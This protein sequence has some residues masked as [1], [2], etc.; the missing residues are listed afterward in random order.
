MKKL[1]LL[2]SFLICFVGFG[3]SIIVND[4]AAPETNFTP[5]ELITE[6]LIGGEGCGDVNFQLLQE[7]PEGTA[8]IA[9]RSWGYFDA[10]GTNFPFASG[11]ILSTGLS[12]DAQGP[13]TETGTTGTGIGWGGDPDLK[14][15]LDLQSGDNEPTN[16]ATIFQFSFVPVISEISFD[17]IFASEEYEN[18]FECDS[19]YRDGFAFLLRGPGIPNDSGTVFGGTNIAAVPG[20]DGIPV[21]TL[22]I[23]DGSFTCGTE[24]EGTNFFPELYISNSGTNNA[25]EIE[26]DG[27]TQ[28]LTAQANLTPGETYELKMVIAD[29][30]DTSFDSAVFFNAGSF[31]IGVNLGDDFT[32]N[33]GNAPCEGE[34]FEI[35]VLPSLNT[36]Y[37]WYFLDPVTMDF[38][39]LP[40]E[41]SSTITINNSGTYQLEASIDGGCI[42]TDEIIVEFAP[43]PTAVE[44][45]LIIACDTIPN[46]GFAEFDLTIRDAQIQNGQPSTTVTYF[47]TEATAQSGNF[48]ITNPTIFENTEPDIQTI[49]AR[50]EETTYGCF[51]IVELDL[52]VDMAPMITDP[53]DSYLV[54]DTDQDGVEVYDLRSKDAE[55]L[56]TQV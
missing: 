37:Q 20:S 40:G 36:S 51:D 32:L 14:T 39:I 46:D 17:F 54:C 53:I 50:L 18:D 28:S 24:I 48:P 4:A 47:R 15:I 21:S 55:I 26:F 42:A 6:V 5:E 49:Y 52:R 45:D 2:I 25:N 16:N 7:N 31:N 33:A 10:T 3:Q 29:R 41:T 34:D 38:N 12:K 44:P 19:Q 23:H 35:G 1:I 56:N 43:Q 13:N 27:Y 11:V 8:N 9:N 22:S 30:G